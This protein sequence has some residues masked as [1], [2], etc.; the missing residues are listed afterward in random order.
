MIECTCNLCHILYFQT[1]VINLCFWVAFNWKRNYNEIF[2]KLIYTHAIENVPLIAVSL[3]KYIFLIQ[4]Q[5]VVWLE[6]MIYN[7][8]IILITTISTKAIIIRYKLSFRPHCWLSGRMSGGSSLSGHGFKPWLY[9][10][11]DTYCQFDLL[12]WEGLHHY[13]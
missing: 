6:N 2:K 7:Y 8:L 11:N 1:S 13:C 3:I 10:T 5:I 12:I 9:H 4:V